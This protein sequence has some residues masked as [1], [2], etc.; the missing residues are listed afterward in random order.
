M[1]WL[2]RSPIPLGCSVIFY[3]FQMIS[4][5]LRGCQRKGEGSQHP[6]GLSPFNLMCKA[7]V[8]RLSFSTEEK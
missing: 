3:M 1:V 7:K 5:C 2:Y 6:A 4:T 8:Q